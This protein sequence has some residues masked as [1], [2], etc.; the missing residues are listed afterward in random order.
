M[1][2]KK[3]RQPLSRGQTIC[4]SCGADMSKSIRRA[5]N[6]RRFLA[7]F[8]LFVILTAGLMA[9]AAYGFDCKFEVVKDDGSSTDVQ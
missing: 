7:L 8:L 2:C 6:R 5:R 4:P 3:C 9:A 1:R